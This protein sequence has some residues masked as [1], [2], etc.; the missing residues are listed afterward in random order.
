M[1]ALLTFLLPTLL[2]L[3]D[4]LVPRPNTDRGNWLRMLRD[5]VLQGFGRTLFQL[6]M[7]PRDC[8]LMLDA[9]VRTLGRLVVRQR[10]L[11]WNSAAQV[12]ASASMTLTSFVRNMYAA[13]AITACVLFVL[14]LGEPVGAHRRGAVPR[15]VVRRADL[16]V[17]RQP[18]GARARSR[19]A[20][21]ERSR[22][23]AR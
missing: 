5:D 17:A 18:A 19:V 9:I 2:A 12:Q 1:L 7:L 8:V 23:V 4:R 22:A 6:A 16:R 13:L 11:E 15:A 14:L 21:A 20:D 10:L 3:V